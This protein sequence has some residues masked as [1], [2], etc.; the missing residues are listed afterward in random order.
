MVWICKRNTYYEPLRGGGLPY[1]LCPAWGRQQSVMEQ[2]VLSTFRDVWIR[3]HG[4]LSTWTE[5]TVV[6]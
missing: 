1:G 3:M 4:W 6:N 5:R 2:A